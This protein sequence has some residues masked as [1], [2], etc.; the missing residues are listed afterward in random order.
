MSNK[1]TEAT[2]NYSE[3]QTERLHQFVGEVETFDYEAAKVI[4]AELG[5]KPRSIIAKARRE[6]LEYTAKPAYVPKTGAKVEKKSDIVG[7]IAT[8]LDAG[9]NSAL[10]NLQKADK[11]SLECLRELIR[12]K[13]QANDA[14]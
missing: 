10:D 2:P 1:T 11:R 14:E 12:S 6:G 5:K 8:L 13:A 3:E 4:A 9:D 7:D